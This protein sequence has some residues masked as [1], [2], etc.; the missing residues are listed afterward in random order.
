MQTPAFV[1]R[2]VADESQWKSVRAI[3]EEVF[4]VEQNCPPEEEWDA[5]EDVSR[6]LLGYLGDM[7]IATARWRV[8]HFDGRAVA[9]L[10]RFAVLRLYRGNGYGRALVRSTI[11]DACQAGFA[12][13][14]IHAQSHLEGFYEALGFRTVSD[15]FFEVGIPHVAM[16]FVTPEGDDAH[17]NGESAA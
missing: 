3:R 10:E 7:P 2:P 16:L 14:L 12:R 6:H 13:C 5:Y 8:K 1:V 4:V 11:E 9:K 17:E 15:E